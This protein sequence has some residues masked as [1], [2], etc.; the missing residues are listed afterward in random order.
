MVERLGKY[1]NKKDN[2]LKMFDNSR[3]DQQV[4]FVKLV[5]FTDIDLPVILLNP[6]QILESKF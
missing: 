4:Q 1:I 6:I 5:N 2:T 3:F